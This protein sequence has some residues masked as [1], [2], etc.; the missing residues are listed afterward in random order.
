M[1][2]L[3]IYLIHKIFNLKERVTKWDLLFLSMIFL[4]NSSLAVVGDYSKLIIYQN[5]YSSLNSLGR[6][7][8]MEK[9]KI[10]RHKN[11]NVL[12]YKYGKSGSEFHGN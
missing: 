1:E 3:T 5:D 6:T 2:D 7:Q 8:F 9:L 4:F 10:I 12:F 11:I